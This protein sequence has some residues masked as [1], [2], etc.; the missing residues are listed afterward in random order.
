MDPE[1]LDRMCKKISQLTRVI[2]LL[3]TRNEE[4]DGMIK[5]I[6][7]SYNSELE[8][9]RREAN[10]VI[11]D[12][13]EKNSKLKDT[14]IMDKKVEEI[15]RKYDENTF[16]LKNSYELLKAE[17][18]REKEALKEEYKQKY[19]EQTKEITTLKNMTDKKLKDYLKNSQIKIK[20]MFE[21]K[22]KEIEQLKKEIENQQKNYEEKRKK[23][24]QKQK[25]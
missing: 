8:N 3:N 2:Y 18:K 1:L 16:K 4:H 21:D 17:V 19:D 11:S 15:K 20:N 23:K 25:D 9:L 6:L 24:K 14:T 22:D 13:T 10:T 12:L 5:S 7:S